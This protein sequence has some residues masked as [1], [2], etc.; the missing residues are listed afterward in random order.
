M[1]SDFG[2]RPIPRRAARTARFNV[3]CVIEAVPSEPRKS[4]ALTPNVG[5]KARNGKISSVDPVIEKWNEDDIDERMLTP[6]TITAFV[7]V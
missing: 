3:A 1:A 4:D 6:D 2:R 5:F 7:Y